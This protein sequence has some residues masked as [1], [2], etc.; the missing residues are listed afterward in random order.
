[1]SS[2]HA[3]PF[4]IGHRGAVGIMPENTLVAYRF[5]LEQWVDGIE[6]DVHLSRD[7]V[8]VVI[9][10]ADLRRTMGIDGFVHDMLFAGLRK[11]DAAAV[12]RAAAGNSTDP[13]ILPALQDVLSWVPAP[14]LLCIELKTRQDGTTYAGLEEIVVQAVRAAG[15]EERTI[16]SSFN[17]AILA[18]LREAAPD[19][20][21]HAII[22]GGYFTQP[23]MDDCERVAADLAAGHIDWVA[24]NKAYL[25]PPL[26]A[27][28]HHH[29]IRTHTWVINTVAEYMHFA[30]LGVTAV[31]TDRPDILCASR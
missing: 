24:V 10:D 21:R 12:Y 28:L 26:A 4:I 17:F 9:H 15:A 2:Q 1:M 8:P 27:A 6:F 11:L 22:A 23:G 16:L 3:R 25:T 29:G 18:R 7:G 31:T 5:A 30:D 13:Q 14:K 20:R 19:I